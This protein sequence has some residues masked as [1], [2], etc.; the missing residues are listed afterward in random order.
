MSQVTSQ[1]ITAT[2]DV[3]SDAQ[4]V[5][6]LRQLW[7]DYMELS[8]ARL[9]GLV[10]ITTAVGYLLGVDGPI[11]WMQLLWTLVGTSL[12]AAAAAA[13]NQVME[14]ERDGRMNRTR[15][16]PLPAGRIGT[17]H[18]VTFGILAG[19][20]GV[21]LLAAMVNPLTAA[22]GLLT[23]ILYLV[24]Y[25][26]L[27]VR[28]TL[29]TLVGAVVG[30]IPPMI[31]W[32]AATGQIGAGAWVLGATLFVWQVPHFLALAW[33]Y[34]DDYQLG[35]YRMLPIIDPTGGITCRAVLAWSAALVP[36]TLA[37]TA[38]GITG[39]IYA[40]GALVLG[41]WLIRLG[42]KL[43]Y[44]R[45]QAA[46]RKLFLAT[47]MYLPLLMGLAVIDRVGPSVNLSR[48]VIELQG[49]APTTVPVSA[50]APGLTSLQ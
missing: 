30:G 29:N 20:L 14:I 36:V 17:M 6:A 33:M 7:H 31:G 26:P 2:V 42:T 38:I 49:P 35:G 12:S 21:S 5:M 40:V 43:Y 15:L 4:P 28:S 41:L 39:W 22:L 13:L 48:E 27:K 8:K 1:P 24:V 34:R 18:A 25:T 23:I 45:T 9:S 32:T 50:P 44:N 19:G 16:R 10:V 3:D 11:D 46:A 47:V 37:A